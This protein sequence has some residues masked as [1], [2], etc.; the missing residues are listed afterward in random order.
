MS[1]SVADFGGGAQYQTT[2]GLDDYD[3]AWLEAN[4]MGLEAAAAAENSNTL[5]ASAMKEYIEKIAIKHEEEKQAALEKQYAEFERYLQ[6][7]QQQPHDL[8]T[9]TPMSPPSAFGGVSTPI[10]PTIAGGLPSS[11]SAFNHQI[12]TNGTTADK[13]KFLRWAERR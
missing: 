5:S 3:R 4:S 2:N 12:T 8:S 1:T 11:T 10:A 7:L 13:S 6:C 9:S